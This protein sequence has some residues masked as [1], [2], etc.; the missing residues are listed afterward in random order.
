MQISL[1]NAEL[2]TI[3][4]LYLLQKFSEPLHDNMHDVF[5]RAADI[6]CVISPISFLPWNLSLRKILPLFISQDITFP[7]SIVWE[8]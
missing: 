5:L 1:E 8:K 2:I 7:Q 4:K 6:L 3:L